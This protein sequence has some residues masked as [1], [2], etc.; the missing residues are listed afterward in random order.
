M[1]EIVPLSDELRK[2]MIAKIEMAQIKNP[3]LIKIIEEAQEI[4]DASKVTLSEESRFTDAEMYE[5]IRFYATQATFSREGIFILSPDRPEGPSIHIR[6]S[7]NG[8]QWDWSKLQIKT[9]MFVF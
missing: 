6:V 7:C 4:I 1:I 8:Q 3:K 5:K 2:Q 9:I